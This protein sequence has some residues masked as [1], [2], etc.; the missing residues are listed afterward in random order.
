M[1]RGC[2][3]LSRSQLVRTCLV[4]P[5][6]CQLST[7]APPSRA[8]LPSLEPQDSPSPTGATG[9]TTLENLLP[10]GQGRLKIVSSLYLGPWG[11][12]A[13]FQP[14]RST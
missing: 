9:S 11:T 8:S 7:A 3:C 10:H 5:P 13:K 14:P 1:L 2:T 4:A 6:L 12:Q